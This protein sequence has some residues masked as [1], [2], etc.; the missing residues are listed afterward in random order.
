MLITFSV[1]LG[2]DSIVKPTHDDFKIPALCQAISSILLPSL[3]QWSNCN[4]VIPHATG[5][6]K[7]KII[8]FLLFYFLKINSYGIIFVKSYSPP[9]PTSTIATSIFSCVN[10]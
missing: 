4:D 1:L 3:S 6:L 7:Q 8:I 9:I 5:F 10:M 2:F